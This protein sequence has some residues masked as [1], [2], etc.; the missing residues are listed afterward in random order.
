MFRSLVGSLRRKSSTRST[1]SSRST[2]S[3]LFSNA[4]NA[5]S[6][7]TNN[8]EKIILTGT[9][10]YEDISFKDEKDILVMA[11]LQAPVFEQNKEDK[12]PPVD[13]CCVIDRS[14]SMEGEK[15]ELVKT[16]MLFVIDNLT[17]QDSLC[18][19]VYDTDVAT[20]L[21]FTSMDN[22]GKKLA[23]EKVQEIYSGSSTNLSGGLF[24]G[25]KN[26][27]KRKSP[28]EI[29]SILLFTDGLANHGVTIASEIIAQME[30]SLAKISDGKGKSCTVFTFGFGYDHNEE[31]L[32]SIAEAGR[33]MYYYVAGADKIP[34]SFADCLGGLQSVVAQNLSLT[35][36]TASP[37]IQ[38]LK[39]L[40]PKYKITQGTLPTKESK[41]SPKFGI[42]LELGDLYSEEKR[43][44]LLEIKIPKLSYED[45]NYPTISFKLNYF[46]VISTQDELVE[47]T[48]VIKR[49]ETVSADL[50]PSVGLDIQRNRLLVA[51]A[52]EEGRR[53]ANA[54]DLDS[55]RVGMEDMIKLV[56][57]SVSYNDPYCQNLVSEMGECIS[58]MQSE[59]MY[60]SEGAKKISRKE[61]AHY[62]QR[63]NKIEESEISFYETS[64]KASYKKS[65]RFFS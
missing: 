37:H 5:S 42:E 7:A 19:V 52:M 3:S 46:N 49:S 11:S 6:T 25:I 63:S 22:S 31:M 55:A 17:S 26:V 38:I 1:S 2:A 51:N 50:K 64:T 8:T 53:K 15:L 60:R 9:P 30:P 58:D 61:Q 35:I 20:P 16:A 56:Q 45:E 4:S 34:L 40:N 57:N 14:G 12:K 44:I 27:S 28:N 62:M 32:R 29:S 59:E 39:S 23:K 10:E 41:T 54:G 33:G 24:E 36:E 21:K 18:V 47:I 48:V 13:I 43:D 65:A